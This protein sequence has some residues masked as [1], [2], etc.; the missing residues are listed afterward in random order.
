MFGFTILTNEQAQRLVDIEQELV[1]LNDGIAESDR[2]NK[3]ILDANEQLLKKLDRA[4][5]TIEVHAEAIKEALLKVAE[6]KKRLD[7]QQQLNRHLEA[8]LGRA[9]KVTPK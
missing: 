9:N 5:Q 7:E 3:K 4:T 2:I 1:H 6:L 8:E